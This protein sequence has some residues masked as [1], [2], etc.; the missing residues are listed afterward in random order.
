MPSH[1][2]G[3]SWAPASD[4]ST[5]PGRRSRD[6][7][8]LARRGLRAGSSS[9]CVDE[10]VEAVALRIGPHSTE[11]SH[12]SPCVWSKVWGKVW[13]KTWFTVWVKG[14]IPQSSRALRGV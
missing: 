4:G 8:S 2:A 12:P 7:T 11:H 10:G 9:R 3:T 5:R 13:G 6:A 1:A 14:P